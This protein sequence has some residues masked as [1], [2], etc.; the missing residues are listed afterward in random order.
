MRWIESARESVHTPSN[1]P[2]TTPKRDFMAQPPH[3]RELNAKRQQEKCTS[4]FSEEF[5]LNRLA[6]QAFQIR[7]IELGQ[8]F[9]FNVS[10]S[11]W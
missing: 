5:I 3:I 4:F 9:N 8:T 11:S 7:L 2:S 1:S 10:K 6:S